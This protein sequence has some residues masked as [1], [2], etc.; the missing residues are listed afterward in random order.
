MFLLFRYSVG[1]IIE[2]VILAKGKNRM[3][4]AASGFAD[5]IEFKRSGQKWFSADRQC[6]ELE[7]VMS[8]PNDADLEMER[9]LQSG[10]V[11]GFASAN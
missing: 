5:T 7:F 1:I 4:V 9:P 2:G 8:R 10:R 6:V 11:M 3:R